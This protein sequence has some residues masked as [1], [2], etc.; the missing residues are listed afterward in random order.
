MV[1]RQIRAVTSHHCEQSLTCMTSTLFAGSGDVRDRRKAWGG[2][3]KPASRR[4]VGPSIRKACDNP[5]S[6]AFAMVPPMLLDATCYVSRHWTCTFCHPCEDA[7]N[8]LHSGTAAKRTHFRVQRCHVLN[9]LRMS[10]VQSCCRSRATDIAASKSHTQ[11]LTPT[12]PRRAACT[13]FILRIR[14]EWR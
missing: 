2:N 14:T 13:T 12:L 3:G 1:L 10:H 11:C 5:P 9:C 8:R 6:D 7:C 4:S